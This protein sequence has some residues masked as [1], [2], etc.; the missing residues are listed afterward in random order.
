VAGAAVRN[1]WFAPRVRFHGALVRGEGLREGSPILL[2]GVEVGEVG[3]LTILDDARIDVEL[4]VLAEHAHR[5]RV[6]THA[7]ARR[8][9]GIGEK[10][11]H[12]TAEGPQGEPLKAG[13]SLAIDEPMDLLEAAGSLDLSQSMRVL[14]R[15]IGAVERLL[16]KFD[17]DGRF[18]RLVSAFDRAGPTLEKVDS[19]LDDV[20]A[21]LVSL[22]ADPDLKGAVS[23]LNGVLNDPAT[24][25]TLQRAS[26]LLAPERLDR[27]LLRTESVLSRVDALTADKGVLNATLTQANRLMSD[28]RADRLIDSVE[29]LTD[30]KK[31]GKIIDNTAVLAEQMGRVGPEIPA[32]TREMALTLREAVVV[33]KALQQTWML[34]GKADKARRELER[35]SQAR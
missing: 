17:E 8:L 16:A 20:H 7:V 19:L 14:E 30:E 24:R 15:S 34:E 12:L 35:D 10:R 3:K 23:G 6:G 1:R 13:S 33:L 26:E 18:E 9:F 5:V 4:V 2:S 32:L 27:L 25:R 21:P 31:L 11:L 22:L 29:R 28:G